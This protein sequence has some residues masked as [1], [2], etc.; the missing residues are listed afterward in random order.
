MK[1]MGRILYDSKC[2]QLKPNLRPEV[3]GHSIDNFP[4]LQD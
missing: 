3:G 2:V 1:Q 4:A